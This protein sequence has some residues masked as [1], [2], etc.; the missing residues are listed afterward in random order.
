[1]YEEVKLMESL[2]V[3]EGTVVYVDEAAEAAAHADATS[4]AE[5]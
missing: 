4:S 5:R 1:V 2:L 3:N